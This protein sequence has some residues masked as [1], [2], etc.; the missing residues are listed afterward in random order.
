MYILNTLDCTYYKQS[1]E[2]L[3]QTATRTDLV[4]EHRFPFES[5]LSGIL[6]PEGENN[7]HK[8][9]YFVKFDQE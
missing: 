3:P 7:R 6:N 4:A 8:L 9:H 5:S 2:I 1:A